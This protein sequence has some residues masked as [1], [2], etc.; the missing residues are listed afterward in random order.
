MIGFTAEYDSGEITVDVWEI[1]DAGWF[2]VHNLPEL[3][4]KKS[5]ARKLIDWY[6]ENRLAKAGNISGIGSAQDTEARK[7]HII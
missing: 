2:D 3:P 4:P 5:I 7:N 1:T 6:I